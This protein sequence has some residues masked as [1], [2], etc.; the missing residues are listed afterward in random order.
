MQPK[1]FQERLWQ[2]TCDSCLTTEHSYD[3]RIRGYLTQPFQHFFCK[4]QDMLIRSQK[5][6]SCNKTVDILITVLL[7]TSRYQDTFSCLATACWRPIC[8]KLLQTCCKLMVKTNVTH[9]PVASSFKSVNDKLQLDESD[10]F[11]ATCW[12]VKLTTCNKAVAVRTVFNSVILRTAFFPGCDSQTTSLCIR[13]RSA[14][15]IG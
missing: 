1:V 9:R 4:T 3:G 15:R 10:K 5:R 12:L 11:V 2:P 13:W 6:A 8:C 14:A 7:S